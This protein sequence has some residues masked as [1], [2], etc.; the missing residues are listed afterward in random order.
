MKYLIFL[1]F[2]SFLASCTTPLPAP[3]TTVISVLRDATDT[4]QSQP[5]ISTLLR[6][7]NC[8]AFPDGECLFRARLITDLS[9]TSGATCHLR[10]AK[11]M[12]SYNRSGDPQFRKKLIV[13]FYDTVRA[14][15][16]RNAEAAAQHQSLP[17]TECMR[18]ICKELTV[19]EGLPYK[20]KELLIYSDLFENAA[21]NAYRKSLDALTLA[22][23]IKRQ[24]LLP[25]RLDGITVR[26]VFTP[27]NRVQE[28][29]YVPIADAYKTVIEDRGGQVF[30][31][32]TDTE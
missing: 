27:L 17:Q 10:S 20:R 31:Q 12:R 30:I 29:R 1:L 32:A 21:F 13:A 2:G 6:A 11:E 26:L 9:I 16:L 23:L 22:T 7:F 5:S 14:L 3:T 28:A 8:E 24:K 18:A 15:L 19:L 25:P 4:I